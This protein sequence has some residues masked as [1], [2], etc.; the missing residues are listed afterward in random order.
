M[1]GAPVSTT[2]GLDRLNGFVEG[3]AVCGRALPPDLRAD[4]DFSETS[5]Y[6][7]MQRLL[8]N[9]PEAVFV[10]SDTMA[11][12][13]LRALSEARVRVPEDV[14][15]VGFDGLP[16]SENSRPTLTTLRQPV[17]QTGVRAVHLLNDLI[18]GIAAPPAIEILPVELVVRES[19]GAI[20][21]RY[22]AHT[23]QA[24]QRDPVSAMSQGS[25]DNPE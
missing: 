17:S 21:R 13:A 5:G 18:K 23:D 22:S 6:R 4:G 12:G 8:P 19:C 11:M 3:L 2:A 25:S 9:R 10:A 16:A 20:H 14:A 24:E 15:L 7:A 1:I